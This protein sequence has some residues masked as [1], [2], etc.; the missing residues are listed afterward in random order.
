MKNKRCA[1]EEK[2]VVITETVAAAA[3]AVQIKF[4]NSHKQLLFF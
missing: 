1:I 3:T 4:L 2:E